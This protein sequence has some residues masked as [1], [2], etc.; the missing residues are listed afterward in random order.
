MTLARAIIRVTERG[1]KI[2]RE[3]R[4]VK[5]IEDAAS[6]AHV[7]RVAAQHLQPEHAGRIAEAMLMP[8]DHVRDHAARLMRETMAALE[9]PKHTSVQVC[10]DVEDE[11]ARQVS[12]ESAAKQDRADDDK[13][14]RG[15]TES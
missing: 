1:D 12:R 7:C 4:T 10:H 5:G 2:L 11:W 15:E 14:K 6:I 3:E 13:N 8:A 9:L